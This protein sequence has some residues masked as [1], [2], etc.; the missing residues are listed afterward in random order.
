MSDG[1]AMELCGTKGSYQIV[2]D[3]VETIELDAVGTA[4]E[5]A[6]FEVGVRSRLCW[7]FS[8]RCEM[9]LY[10]SGKLMVRTEDKALAKEVAHLHV[11]EW[12]QS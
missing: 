12:V 5:A 3:G 8:G 11:H 1:F 9:T 4:I 7:T 2:P 10:P 6:G